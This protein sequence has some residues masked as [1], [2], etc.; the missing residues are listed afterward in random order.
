MGRNS[1]TGGDDDDGPLVRRTYARTWR[2][3]PYVDKEAKQILDDL[4]FQVLKDQPEH[5]D[6]PENP[7]LAELLKYEK[8]PEDAALVTLSDLLAQDLTAQ[9]AV[10][11]YFFRYCQL[12]IME[13]YYATHGHDTGGDPTDRRNATRNIRRTLHTAGQKLGER[14]AI[15]HPDEEDADTDT[16]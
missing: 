11:W 9:E 7:T 15:P 1:T 14:V 6:D 12:S 8:G 5:I 10:M 13:I 3:R 4:S 2:Q 16:A